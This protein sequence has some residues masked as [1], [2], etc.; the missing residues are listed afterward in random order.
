M[1]G[2]KKDLEDKNFFSEDT[3]KLLNAKIDD[4]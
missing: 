4:E 3:A 1:K 2:Q